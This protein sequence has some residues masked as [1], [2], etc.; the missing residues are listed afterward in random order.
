MECRKRPASAGPCELDGGRRSG[1]VPGAR[2]LGPR[3]TADRALE[4]RHALCDLRLDPA[5]SG[6]RAL[7]ELLAHMR[8]KLLRT[9]RAI[10]G[11]RSDAED[12]VQ[13]SLV[14]LQQALPSFRG[15]C[16]IGGFAMTIVRRRA[17]TMRRRRHAQRRL[18]STASTFA[19]H[20]VAAGAGTNETPE[21]HERYATW[22]RLLAGLPPSQAEALVLRVVFGC[23]LTEVALRTGVPRN[24]VRS[25]IR[26]AREALRRCIEAAPT[27]KDLLG[28]TRHAVRRPR[29]D[30]LGR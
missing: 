11:S 20:S 6:T 28:G 21:V 1:R 10:L 14:A 23:S 26:L 13:E 15:E 4:Y 29:M 8:P 22:S 30:S 27:L 17:R 25:R 18:A 24:T 7:D 5:Q 2:A 3:S 16:E 12:C 9:A 19:E